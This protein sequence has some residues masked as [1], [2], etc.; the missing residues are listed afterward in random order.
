QREAGEAEQRRE[1]IGAARDVSDGRSLQRV[2]GPDERRG[3]REPRIFGAQ[4]FLEK[5]QRDRGGGVRADARE[6]PAPRRAESVNRV[7]RGEGDAL[8]QTIEIGCGRIEKQEVPEALGNEPPTA[9]RWIA[10]DER[11]VVPDKSVAERGPV[12]EKR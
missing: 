7:V 2:H 1:R 12:N 3:K 6:M 5:K 11:G 4:F 8:Q 9:D 10:Q